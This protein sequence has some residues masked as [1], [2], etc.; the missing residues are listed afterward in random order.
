MNGTDDDNMPLNYHSSY[1]FLNP[2]AGLTYQPN[3]LSKITFLA[4]IANRE[5]TRADIKDA[6]KGSGSQ[7]PKPETMLDLELGCSYNPNDWKISANA[8]FMGYND[9]LVASGKLNN[10]GYAL[11]ENVEKSYRIGIEI[12]TGI[13][14]LSWLK[15]EANI[16]L[17]QN[18]IINYIHY[19]EHYNNPNDWEPMAQKA[20]NY[21]NTQL[22]FSP[23][24]V[25]AALVSIEPIKN[26]KLQLT[27]KYVGEQYYDNTERDE[28]RLAPYCVVNTKCSYLHKLNGGREIE[29]Q[30]LVN[31]IFDK[32]YINNAWGYEAY[33]DDGSE[34][35]IEQGFF[36]QPGINAT[37]RM[38]I[39]L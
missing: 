36:V 22:A 39:R 15:A 3:N 37:A 14:M 10:V 35:Y 27:A 13:Q 8:Y 29:F 16:T 21:G 11:M 7:A 32:Q 1:H 20:V 26:L 24:V 12:A 18:K 19:E 34:K 2:K 30:L 6:I 17:S 38:V 9:Q 33:F 25:G 23:N 5:P 28:T 31:N 4:S